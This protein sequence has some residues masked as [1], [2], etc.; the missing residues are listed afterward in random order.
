MAKMT[1][2]L[3]KQ[4]LERAIKNLQDFADDYKKGISNSIKAATER[5]YQ[6]IIA[7]CNSENVGNYTDAIQWEYD[8]KKNVGRVW[9]TSEGKES[10]GL[11]IILNEFGTGIKGTQDGYANKHGY[12]VNASGKGETGWAFPTKNGEFKWTHGLPSKHM[13]YN[14]FQDVK[15]E[16]GDI[17]NIELQGTI[18]KLYD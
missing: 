14:A 9:V 4:S 3:S 6:L 10:H 8:E 1:I 15:R 17:I 18:G 16:F 5:L 13:F 12:K 11:V 2:E 7:Y